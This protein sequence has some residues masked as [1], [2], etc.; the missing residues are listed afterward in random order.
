MKKNNKIDVPDVIKLYSNGYIN[1]S[2]III[3]FFKCEIEDKIPLLSKEEF[4]NYKKSG[5][6]KGDVK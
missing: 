2:K 5:L 4:E 3:T 1:E 6:K